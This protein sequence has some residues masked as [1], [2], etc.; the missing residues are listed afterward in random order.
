[1]RGR[2]EAQGIMF[3]AFQSE[4]CGPADHPLRSIKR[5]ADAIL[6]D[7]SP[8]FSRA[9]RQHGAPSIP[10]ERLIKALL[11]RALYS[12]RSA[13]LLVAQIGYNFLFR[14]FHDL[15]PSDGV[16]RPGD[17]QHEPETLRRARAG[18]QVLRPCR[19]P[20]HRGRSG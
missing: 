4:D 10:P 7:L 18:A 16:S 11:L 14:W 12:I 9:Y 13:T 3:H 17:L 20:G 2:V 8:H 6:K 5:R 19:G 1:M 15:Q